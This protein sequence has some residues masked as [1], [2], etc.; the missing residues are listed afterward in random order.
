[1]RFQTPTK[2]DARGQAGKGQ[3]ARNQQ[4]NHTG[5]SAEA[6]RVRLLDCLQKFGMI[7]TITARRE[8][9]IMMPATR[10]F[11]LRKRGHHIDMVWIERPTD[12]GKLHRVA[13]YVLGGAS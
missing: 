5:N 9:D 1:M 13:L 2:D 10:I 8:L 3:A 4:P 6:Q 12:C 7:D 11:E